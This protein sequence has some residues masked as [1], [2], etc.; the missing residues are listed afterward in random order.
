[1]VKTE[2]VFLLIADDFQL[3]QYCL[4]QVKGANKLHDEI[5]KRV[6]EE[7]KLW[8]EADNDSY[9]QGNTCLEEWVIDEVCLAFFSFN[10]DRLLS[11]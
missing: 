5:N 7:P 10:L 3:N 1:M 11:Q 2:D 8:N 4:T 9:E 6:C